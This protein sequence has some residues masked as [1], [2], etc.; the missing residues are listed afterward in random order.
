MSEAP[1]FEQEPRPESSESFPDGVQYAYWSQDVLRGNFDLRAQ[2]TQFLALSFSTE[3]KPVAAEQMDQDIAPDVPGLQSFFV[4]GYKDGV[5]VS[6]AQAIYI[7]VWAGGIPDVLQCTM[8]ATHPE[9]R[10][11]GFAQ[12]AIDARFKE[13]KKRFPGKNLLVL[14]D[15]S[16]SDAQPGLTMYFRESAKE[17]F[18][19]VSDTDERVGKAL[20]PKRILVFDKNPGATAIQ[21]Q[22]HT[23]LES[24]GDPVTG[25]EKRRLT[26]TEFPPTDT[27]LEY[28]PELHEVHAGEDATVFM[29]PHSVDLV[30]LMSDVLPGVEIPVIDKGVR[31][32]F[33]VEI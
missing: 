19:E 5:M 16:D 4:V 9:Y 14:A 21:L 26:V 12:H 18:G 2:L 20:A 28:G 33:A 13:T 29:G 1:R 11:Q 8:L 6:A 30:Q 31:S 7:P 32:A 22:I 3:D 15:H 24:G 27:V 17:V 23:K 10:H 25:I